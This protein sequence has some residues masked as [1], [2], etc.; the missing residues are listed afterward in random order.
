M[1]TVCLMHKLRH[2]IDNAKHNGCDKL[3]YMHWMNNDANYIQDN[4]VA[5]FFV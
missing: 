2:F 3:I 1:F 4:R 5:F